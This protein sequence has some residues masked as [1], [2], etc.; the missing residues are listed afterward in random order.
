MDLGRHS[1]PIP[2][3]I[4]GP[5]WATNTTLHLITWTLKYRRIYIT[6]DVEGCK[7][8]IFSCANIWL[9]QTS[10]AVRSFDLI[11]IPSTVHFELKS[12]IT[13][14][15]D[16]FIKIDLRKWNCF[17]FNSH[18]CGMAE[19]RPYGFRIDFVRNTISRSATWFFEIILKFI[20]DPFLKT[21]FHYR[22]FGI[23][24]SK[25]WFEKRN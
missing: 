14:N 6:Y 1:A 19:A 13:S 5:N 20:L 11:V 15:D 12:T 18:G 9:L 4:F 24:S 16:K 22:I 17:G 8:N 10:A 2:A 21:K 25:L 3:I 23:F 7:Q